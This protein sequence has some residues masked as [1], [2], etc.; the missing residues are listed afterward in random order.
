MNIDLISVVPSPYQQ[1]LFHALA[2]EPDCHLRVHYLE[3]A[4]PDSPWP[5][6][7]L[8][9]YESVLPGWTAGKGRVRCHTNWALPDFAD[10]DV[11]IVNASLTGLTTQQVMHRL[12]KRGV[13][14]V[15][16]GETLRSRSGLTGLVQQAIT[17]K[18]H[19]ASSIVAIG[20]VAQADY[21]HRFPRQR[22]DQLP[23]FCDLT[24]FSKARAARNNTNSEPVFLFCGQ[25]IQRK[26]IDVLLDAFTSAV[27][28]G[29]KARLVLVGREAGLSPLLAALPEVVRN[30]I[31]FA[32][33][34]SPDNLPEFFA[35]ADVFVLPSHH[36]GWGVVINQALG[37]GLP[38]ITTEA[39][40]AARD[41]VKPGSNG[42]IVPAGKVAPLA[43]ALLQLG[44]NTNLRLTMSQES[45]RRS[46]SLTPA[47][48][49]RSFLDILHEVSNTETSLVS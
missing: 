9:S 33:F 49:A 3:D 40:G 2:S 28:S 21:Q 37:A 1:D 29:F 41:L 8:A 36:D 22:V 5:Q 23:Y 17:R 24:A 7:T 19:A 10:T 43:D 25:M 14:W 15:F 12:C 11:A 39:V 31:E 35:K 27:L 44:N 48:G 13:P 4:A 26:G 45:L 18:L 42:I 34:Q 47:A 30:S 20:S 16:W 32:G 38:V 6:R 46:E